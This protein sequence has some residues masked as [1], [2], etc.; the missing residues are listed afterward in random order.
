MSIMSLIQSRDFRLFWALSS[1]VSS[2]AMCIII[3]WDI[4]HTDPFVAIGLAG[5]AIINISA[6]VCLYGVEKAKPL[7]SAIGGKP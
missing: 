5:Y 1:C 4:V 6:A 7:A 2:A 3:W